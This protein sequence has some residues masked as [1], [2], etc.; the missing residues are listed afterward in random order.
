MESRKQALIL[1][2]IAFGL[3]LL[4][5]TYFSTA[6]LIAFAPLI[7]L[8]ENTS[9]RKFPFF[10]WF[11]AAFLVFG[12]NA[13][14]TLSDPVSII[15]YSIG[16]TLACSAYLLTTYFSKNKLG[17]FTL[18]LFWLGFDYLILKSLPTASNAFLSTFFDGYKIVGWSRKTGYFGITAWII[19][20]NILFYYVFL[21]R[22]AIMRSKMRWLSLMYSMLLIII[23]VAISLFIV[24]ELTPVTLAELNTVYVENSSLADL[25]YTEN[26]EWLGRTAAWVSVMILVYAI[27]K[28]KIK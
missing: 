13:A 4:S 27:I 3:V 6:S 22:D 11:G 24:P 20:A 26:G 18:L 15:I 14:L 1:I 21:W 2:V 16:I 25:N 19:I 5:R 28:G 23:P 12:L 7:G 8:L 9:E 17:V 10:Y